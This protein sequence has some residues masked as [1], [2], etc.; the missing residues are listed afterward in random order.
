MIGNVNND[1][2]D[3]IAGTTGLTYT[4]DYQINSRGSKNNKSSLDLGFKFHNVIAC[5]ITVIIIILIITAEL[6]Q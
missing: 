2:D 1:D 3:V 4:D 6:A 5:Y